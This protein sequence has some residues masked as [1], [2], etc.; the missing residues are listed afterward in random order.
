MCVRDSHVRL[1]LVREAVLHEAALAG[2]RGAVGPEPKVRC[3][4]ARRALRAI[5]RRA[6]NLQFHGD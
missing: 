3:T 1:D 2:S 5:D 6:D 4:D